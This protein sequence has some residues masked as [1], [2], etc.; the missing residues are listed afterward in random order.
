MKIKILTT[1][2]V[3]CC[4]F[5]FVATSDSVAQGK[6]KQDVSGKKVEASRGASKYI[7]PVDDTPAPKPTTSRGNSCCID[8][9]N[10]TGYYVDIWVDEVYRG[11]IVPWDQGSICVGAGYT[12]WYAQTIGGT[13]YWGNSGACDVAFIQNLNL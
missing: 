1:G 2:V 11:R 9:S 6:K 10:N 8:F 13:Y 3:L 5:L 7:V 12:K 4:L